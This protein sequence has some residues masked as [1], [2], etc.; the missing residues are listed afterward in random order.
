MT[1]GVRGGV[2]VC[3]VL[4]RYT[5]VLAFLLFFFWVLA[6]SSFRIQQEG[7]CRWMSLERR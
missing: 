5:S 7:E 4:W 2:L 1:D 6:G 3:L